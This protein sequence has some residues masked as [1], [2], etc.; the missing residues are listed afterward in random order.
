MATGQL[1]FR[2]ESSAVIFKAILDA[3][4][5]PIVRL[6]PDVP[7]KLEDIINRALEKDRNLRY[8]HASDMRA[9]LQRLKRDFE[10]S[11]GSAA[12]SG[13]VTVAEAPA[14]RVPKL[15]K[16]AI[17]VLLV[18]LLVAGGLYYR[19]LQQSKRLTEKDTVVLSDFDNKTGDPVFDDALKQALA[20]DLEQSPFLNVLSDQRV[21][22]TLRLMGHSPGD[23]L[24]E[25]VARDL[26][27][28]V[29]SKA[30]LNG[31]IT[32]LGSQ[33]VIG[34]HAINCSNGD[35]LANEQARATGKEQVLKAL[36]QAASRLRAKLGE[37]HSSVQ[38]FDTPIVD[39]TTPS[40][41]ALKAYSLSAGR[42]SPP[43]GTPPP[44]H[45]SSALW[46]WT[47]ASPSG[48]PFWG[49]CTRILANR[50]S[51]R[52]ICEKRTCCVRG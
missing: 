51:P 23:P 12:N 38:K 3:E 34:L 43:R 20:V 4:P 18:A 10:S 11:H 47:P 27:Q 32:A 9:E 36:D 22:A 15:W 39:E 29:A 28:R 8:Q 26:C 14:T 7:P 35:S 21:N 50:S 13:T 16:I 24:T 1:P 37:S 40:L 6:N 52:R 42:S 25:S 46:N 44:F 41:E 19:S 48:T 45:C 31:S 17:P 2:G 5:A 30:V 33:Y 49:W